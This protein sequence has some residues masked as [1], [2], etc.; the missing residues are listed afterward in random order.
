MALYSFINGLRKEHINKIKM[1]PEPLTHMGFKIISTI[2]GIFTVGRLG[3][4]CENQEAIYRQM[5][6]IADLQR[7][8][9]VMSQH[10]EISAKLDRR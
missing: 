6:E 3:V 4:I 2:L 8:S 9:V 5:G 10:R 7:Q 1:P